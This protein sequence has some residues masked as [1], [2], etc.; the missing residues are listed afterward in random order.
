MVTPFKELPKTSMYLYL[1]LLIFQAYFTLFSDSIFKWNYCHRNGICFWF[2]QGLQYVYLTCLHKKYDMN[3]LNSQINSETL[4]VIVFLGKPQKT[5]ENAE[6][7]PVGEQRFL[8]SICS[9]SFTTAGSLRRHEKEF[10]VTSD[11]V[12]CV[13]VQQSV[14]YSQKQ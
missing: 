12:Y 4:T 1:S 13:D 3:E 8:C 5:N 10:H 6:S 9:S 14:F 7:A 11:P 2:C